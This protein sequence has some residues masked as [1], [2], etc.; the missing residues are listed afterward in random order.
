MHRVPQDLALERNTWFH[1]G[2][3]SAQQYIYCLKRM[4]EPIK[5]HVDNNFNPLP[6]AYIEEFQ[7]ILNSIHQLM[8]QS[9]GF[10]STGRY[11]GYRDVMA[12][13]DRCKN[14]L[15]ALRRKHIDRMQQDR[16]S[17]NLQI[18]IVYLNLIQ[19]TQELLSVMRHQLRAT[20][21][22]IGAPG[23]SYSESE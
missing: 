22:F 4:L 14:E 11:N 6:K 8:K 23:V 9:A 2:A 16:N 12:E 19:E 7:P 5:E 20:R 10:I 21:K 15:S 13:A 3:N 18:S 17:K 1:L